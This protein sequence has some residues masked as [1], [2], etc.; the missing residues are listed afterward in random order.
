MIFLFLLVLL[1]FLKPELDPSWRMIS[2]YEIGK[3]GFLM[4]IAFGFLSL[5]CFSLTVVIWNQVSVIADIILVIVSY[6]PLRAAI[7]TTNSITTPIIL[8]SKVG[9]LH[10]IFGV[11]FIFGFPIAKTT[12]YLSKN[13]FFSGSIPIIY[14]L[15]RISCFFRCS[16]LF[17]RK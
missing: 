8:M 15:A 2:E 11:I 1:H 7:F 12:V 13:N 3:Y 14:S 6:G 17:W 4:R 10:T 9:K 5:S 16:H